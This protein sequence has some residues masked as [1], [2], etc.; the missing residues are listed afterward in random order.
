MLIKFISF[1][2]NGIEFTNY[3]E[4]LKEIVNQKDLRENTPLMI[5]ILKRLNYVKNKL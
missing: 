5:C 3:P 4:Q 2:K 1:T